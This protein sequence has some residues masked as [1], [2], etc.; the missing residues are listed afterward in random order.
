MGSAASGSRPA[1]GALASDLAHPLELTC[2]HLHP[3]QIPAF[4]G[5]PPTSHD[6]PSSRS[7]NLDDFAS[8]ATN[9]PC[10][11]FWDHTDGHRV[12]Q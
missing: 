2:G 3:C 7:P 12:R 10:K 6:L 9:S 1:A 5:Y 11:P 4:A 8:R